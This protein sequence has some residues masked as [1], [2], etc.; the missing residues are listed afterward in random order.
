MDPRILPS[1]HPAIVEGHR[2]ITAVVHRDGTVLAVRPGFDET[3]Y[4]VA[5][6]VGSTTIAGYLV[7]LTS[8]DVIADAGVMNPQIR[9]DE[10]LMSRVSYV[11]MNPGGERE[12]TTAVRAAL[13][14]LV[15]EL[16]DRVDGA[17]DH[18]RARIHD[19]SLIHI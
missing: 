7:D 12:L 8:G 15:T 5:V 10:D 1:L 2:G 14:G 13:D 19:L 9:F 3:L 16:S 6:D 11:M 18:V 17:D 4:G